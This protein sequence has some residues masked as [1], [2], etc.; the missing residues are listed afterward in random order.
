MSPAPPGTLPTGPLTKR[1]APGPPWRSRSVQARPSF[2]GLRAAP[3]GCGSDDR[4]SPEQHRHVF[5]VAWKQGQGWCRT[6]VL[7][8]SWVSEPSGQACDSGCTPAGPSERSSAGGGRDPLVPCLHCRR[9]APA[10]REAFGGVPCPSSGCA[11][12]SNH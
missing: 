10:C 2:P 11:F 5:P 3:G 1:Q 6:P 9:P 4:A 8:A 7:S 12:L